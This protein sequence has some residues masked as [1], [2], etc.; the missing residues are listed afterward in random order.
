M[1]LS[2]I[3]GVKVYKHSTGGVEDKVNNH[4]NAI[5]CKFWCACS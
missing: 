3:E 4:F 5:G 1:D 2:S